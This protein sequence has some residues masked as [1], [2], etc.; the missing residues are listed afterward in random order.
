MGEMG[1]IEDLQSKLIMM[2]SAL[3]AIKNKLEDITQI[4]EEVTNPNESFVKAYLDE[5]EKELA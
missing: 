1:I 3:Y 2:D 4:L 5:I